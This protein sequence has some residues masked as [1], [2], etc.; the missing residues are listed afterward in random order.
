MP[1]LSSIV[2]WYKCKT[3]DGVQDILAML[4]L[5]PLNQKLF[6]STLTKFITLTSLGAEKACDVQDL[7]NQTKNSCFFA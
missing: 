7:T 3:F 2:F 5:F 6:I 1:H 4:F